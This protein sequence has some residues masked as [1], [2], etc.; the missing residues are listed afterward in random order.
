MAEFS[1][2]SFLLTLLILAGNT[3]SRPTTSR[4]ADQVSCTMCEECDNPCQLS[5]PMPS[6]PPPVR[7][8]STDNNCPPPPSPPSS[9]GNS[10][11]TTTP[12]V[13]NFPY[14]SPPPPVPAGVY[15]YTTP[16][17]P[18]PI[19][20]Y[21]PFYYLNPPPPHQN[22]FSVQLEINRFHIVF[23]FSFLIFF[24]FFS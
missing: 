15:G 12:S 5:P 20:P 13:P 10:P 17:P 24:L 14:Y 4:I 23:H 9:G 21:F 8:P 7:P 11:P 16:P 6:P 2:F 3:N 1:S 22:S 18:N 19:L